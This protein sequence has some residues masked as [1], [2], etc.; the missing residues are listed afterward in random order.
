MGRDA[1]RRWDVILAHRS[2]AR[3]V[4]RVA[5]ALRDRGERDRTM[6]GDVGYARVDRPVLIRRRD[7]VLVDRMRACRRRVAGAA[8]TTR[9]II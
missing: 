3:R 5:P 6:G 4:D 9:L 1:E 7:V 8:Q 2:A